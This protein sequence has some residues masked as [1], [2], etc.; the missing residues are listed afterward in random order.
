MMNWETFAVKFM[1][2]AIKLTKKDTILKSKLPNS[3]PKSKILKLKLWISEE[4]SMSSIYNGLTHLRRQ[5]QEA[6]TPKS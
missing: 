6:T 4:V 2:N 3:I 1:L 5:I